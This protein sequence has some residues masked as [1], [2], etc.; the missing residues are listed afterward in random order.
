MIIPS[1]T[2]T[3]GNPI[4]AT[5]SVFHIFVLISIRKLTKYKDERNHK[6][7]ATKLFKSFKI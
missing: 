4:S 1:N 6:K 7:P 3:L 2:A 5:Q